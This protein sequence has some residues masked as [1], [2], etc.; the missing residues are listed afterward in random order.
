M[1]DLKYCSPMNKSGASNNLTSHMN[2]ISSDCL[3]TDKLNQTANSLTVASGIKKNAISGPKLQ[4]SLNW[5]TD[6]LCIIKLVLWRISR[7]NS[8]NVLEMTKILHLEMLMKKML[9]IVNVCG[10]TISNNHIINI[11]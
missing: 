9:K 10:I 6:R 5:G 8:Q 7:F 2:N 4:I 1:Q 11:Q 3:G